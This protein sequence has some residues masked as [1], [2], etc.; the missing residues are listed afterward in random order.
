MDYLAALQGWGKPGVNIWGTTMGAPYNPSPDFPGYN[1]GGINQVARKKVVNPVKQKI[2]RLL[3]PDAILNPPIQFG[4][5]VCVRSLNQQFERYR[6]PLEGN[7]EV[8]MYYRY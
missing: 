7:S 3:V 2:N 6:Y 4:P 5:G 1:P 8:R